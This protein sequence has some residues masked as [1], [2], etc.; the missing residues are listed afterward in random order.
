MTKQKREKDTLKK[1]KG[2]LVSL[3]APEKENVKPLKIK[4]STKDSKAKKPLIQV[5]D[6]SL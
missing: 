6:V 1:K 3:I 2:S 4:K 5:E